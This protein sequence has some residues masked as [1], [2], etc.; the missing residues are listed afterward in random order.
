MSSEQARLLRDAIL[1]KRQ[2]PIES[3]WADMVSR[4]VIDEQ[5]NVLLPSMGPQPLPFDPIPET[6]SAPNR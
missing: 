5:G 6:K 3:Q 2:T 1:Q 4:G